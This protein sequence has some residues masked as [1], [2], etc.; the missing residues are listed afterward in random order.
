MSEPV[1]QML[2]HYRLVEKIGEGG[3]GVVWK[4]LDTRLDRHVAIK[5]LPER[6]M[7]DPARRRRLEREARAAASLSH[8]GIAVVHEVGRTMAGSSW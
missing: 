5:M 1:G 2:A 4:A 8:P 6:L 3:M 7:A